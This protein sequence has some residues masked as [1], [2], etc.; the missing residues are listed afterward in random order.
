MKI[1]QFFYRVWLVWGLFSIILSL[2]AFWFYF[3]YKSNELETFV[4]HSKLELNFLKKGV[5]NTLQ[6]GNYQNTIQLV[7][8]WGE[9]NANIYSIELIS[10]NGFNIAQY[11]RDTLS[12]KTIVNNDTI[13]YSYRGNAKLQITHDLQPVYSAIKR[14]AIMLGMVT[15]IGII[16]SLIFAYQFILLHR[17]NKK[18][19]EETQKMLLARQSAEQANQAKSDFLANMS[20]E[21]RTPMHGILGY[22]Q[23]GIR[24]FEKITPEKHRRFL[25]NIEISGQRLLLLL[26]DLLDLSKLESGKMELNIKQHNFEKIITACCSEFAAKLDELQLKIVMDKPDAPILIHC[27]RLRI[28]QVIIN[29]LSNAIKFSPQGSEILFRYSLV[30]N[31]QMELRL[32][33]Q[34]TGVESERLE[35]IFEK[36]VQDESME[37]GTGMGSTGL[38]LAICKQIIELHQGKIWAEHSKDENIGGIFCFS[39]PLHRK[40]DDK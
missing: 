9:L 21:L 40:V 24:Q 3:T 39:L 12:N 37:T 13:S 11:Q 18:L 22:A 6:R 16:A 7:Q 31:T 25:K 34:G 15:L 38:G 27:D 30:D 23:M 5:K 33:D 19:D 10:G 4:T 20:H 29:L 8:E 32:I 17:R 14:F 26:D 36:F 35:K 2:F 28:H 1:D